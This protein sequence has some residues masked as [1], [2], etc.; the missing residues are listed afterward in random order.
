MIGVRL[1]PGEYYLIAQLPMLE[2]DRPSEM[3]AGRT[4]ESRGR[5]LAIP[6]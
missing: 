4:A 5:R 1:P 2:F 3:R 6:L